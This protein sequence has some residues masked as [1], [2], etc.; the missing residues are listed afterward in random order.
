EIT[1]SNWDAIVTV[2][3]WHLNFRSATMQMS[4]TS[5][6][7]LSSTHSTF[8]GLQCTLKDKLNELPADVSPVL[9]LGLTDAHR[10]FDYY[11]KY[12]KSPF[13]IWAAFLDP[14]F[15]YKN[16][17]KDSASEPDLLAYLEDQKIALN[18]YFEK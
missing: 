12:D 4:T 2:S 9:V 17:R 3:H 10:K 7:M 8:R 5:K 18:T 13:Y 1:W 15:N 11:Y 6:P 16:L 14:C